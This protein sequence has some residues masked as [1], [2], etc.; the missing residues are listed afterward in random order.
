MQTGPRRE[1]ARRA[2]GNVRDWQLPPDHH[3]VSAGDAWLLKYVRRPRRA[4]V[5]GLER[6]AQAVA[7]RRWS[8]QDRGDGH[9]VGDVRSRT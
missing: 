9:Q 3:I 1:A 6:R 4:G 7:H 2:L 5:G 8:C